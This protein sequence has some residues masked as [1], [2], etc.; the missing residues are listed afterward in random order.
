MTMPDDCFS[1]D[2]FHQ[3][4]QSS[5]GKAEVKVVSLPDNRAAISRI[6]ADLNS[7]AGG[8]GHLLPLRHFALSL[9]NGDLSIHALNRD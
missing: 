2:V 1:L 5:D 3:G 8:V 7:G 9:I 6:Q 4:G